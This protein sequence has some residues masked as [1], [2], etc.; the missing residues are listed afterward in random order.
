MMNA[1][2]IEK[3]GHGYFRCMESSLWIDDHLCLK[4]QW[5][6]DCSEDKITCAFPKF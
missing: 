5:N 6:I 3:N 2:V 1:C 4:C